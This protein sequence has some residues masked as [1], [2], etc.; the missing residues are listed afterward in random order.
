MV[1][2][3]TMSKS[4]GN[5]VDPLALRDVF[6]TDAVRWYLLREMPTGSDASY[7]PERFAARYD[8]LANV[9]GNLAQRA[10]SMIVRWR[11]GVVPDAPADG[12]DAAIRDTLATV[13]E[14]LAAWRLHDAL[15][16]AMELARTA[17]GYV[18]EREPWAQA[19]DPARAAELDVTL[20]TLAHVL[21][22]LTALFK[23]VCPGKADELA[24]RLGLPGAPTLSAAGTLSLAGHT[25]EAGDPLFPRVQLPTE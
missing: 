5:V 21:G 19:K 16:A 18:E 10:T 17:N 23:P 25:V 24:R 12:L 11:G 2:D 3:T 15:G 7:T 4:L 9:F 8:E 22:V 13:R 1:G 20:A 14:A 6:G